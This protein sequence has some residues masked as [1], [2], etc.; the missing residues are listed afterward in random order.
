[1][2]KYTFKNLL[3]CLYIC[4]VVYLCSGYFYNSPLKEKGFYKFIENY[5]GVTIFIIVLLFFINFL[6]LFIRC[7][8]KKVIF[9]VRFNFFIMLIISIVCIYFAKTVDIHFDKVTATSE[10]LRK[11]TEIGLYKYKIGL[12]FVFILDWIFDK[13]YGIYI[14]IAGYTVMGIS[15][16]FLFARAVRLSIMW[17]INTIKRKA[18]ERKARKLYEEQKKLEEYYRRLKLEKERE[19]QRQREIQA[20]IEKE[21]VLMEQM[22]EKEIPDKNSEDEEENQDEKLE[23]T[24][25]ETVEKD[26][27]KLEKTNEE[28]DDSEEESP[29]DSVQEEILQDENSKTEKT[30]DLILE[31]IEDENDLK[32]EELTIESEDSEEDS[33]N[34]KEDIIAEEESAPK[35]DLE[36]KVKE[37]TEEESL[38][39]DDEDPEKD[40]KEAEI[41]IIKKLAQEEEEKIDDTSL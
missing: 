15:M 17:I 8:K 13:V 38:E 9:N 11:L 2:K 18:N 1:M 4:T 28:T 25:E 32:K 6:S 37:S 5:F 3:I 35:E 19:E 10:Q 30:D 34:E 29:E 33:E 40:Y 39:A 23:T 7:K 27:E 26:T 41:E 16:F 31:K 20:Q 36:M 12:F 24:S 14:Y 21:R 22:G